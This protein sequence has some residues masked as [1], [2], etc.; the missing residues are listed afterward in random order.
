MKAPEYRL[1]PGRKNIY[2]EPVRLSV[3]IPKA[4]LDAL[5]ESD[6]EGKSRNQKIVAALEAVL[7]ERGF[8]ASA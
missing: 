2:E 1:K 4:V 8:P 7:A 6:F 5:E 3:F